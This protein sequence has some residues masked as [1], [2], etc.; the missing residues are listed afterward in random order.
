[1]KLFTIILLATLFACNSGQEVQKPDIPDGQNMFGHHVQRGVT[2]SN[3]KLAEGYVLF[4]P[5][6]SAEVYLVNRAGQVVY[7]WKGNY[8]VMGAYLQSDGSLFQN[9]ADPDFPVF[10]GGGETGRIQRIAPDSTIIWDFEYAT[11]EYHAHHDFAVMPNG[12]VLLIA[13]E[14]KSAEEALQ[15]GR[16][17]EFLPKAGIWPDKIVEVRP[18]DKY[19]GEIVWEWHFWDHL[20]QNIDPTKDNYGDPSE[21]PELLDINACASIPDPISADSVKVLHKMNRL[22]RNQTADNMGSD[23][24]HTNAINYNAELDQIAISSPALNEIFIIDHSTTTEEAAGHQGGRWGKGGDIL[25][26]WGNPENYGQGDSTNRR[27]F[28]QHDVRWIEKGMPGEGNLTIFNNDMDAFGSEQDL[29][30]DRWGYSSVIEIAP[31]TDASGNYIIGDNGRFGPEYPHW[32]YMAPDS[33][34][35]YSSFISGAHR[36]SNGNTFINEGA[37]GRFFEVTPEGEIQW[38]YLNPYRGDIRYLNGDPISPMPMTYF[39]F[40]ATF[41]PADHPGIKQL[42]LTP[43]DPQPEPFRLPPPPPK[44]ESA[45]F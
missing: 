41:I 3:D 19:H 38:E 32:T 45:S 1:M 12:N 36:M 9:A 26:R 22:W 31:T 42:D 5:T 7:V 17:P 20:I 37:R 25:Y 24:H 43:V 21:H 18:T 29:D 27:L 39:Q 16:N 11:E 13:W 33:T 30:P 35:F 4:V 28:H 6:N 14:A 40:R 8:E 15:A 10:A 44:T 34:S 23:I 2:V